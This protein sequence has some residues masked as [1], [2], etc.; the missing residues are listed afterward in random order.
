MDWML[1]DGAT[2][3]KGSTLPE[4]SN[5]VSE[6][7]EPLARWCGPRGAGHGVFAAWVEEAGVGHSESSL[8]SA[9]ACSVP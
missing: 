7:L 6:Y 9:F 2:E 8:L 4:T 1:E 5:M 3:K